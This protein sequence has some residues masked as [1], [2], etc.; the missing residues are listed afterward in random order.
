MDDIDRAALARTWRQALAAGGIE[1]IEAGT[2]G[3]R[4]SGLVDRLAA[5]LDAEPF[6]ATVGV[7]VGAAL[8]AADF[9]DP[10][11]P[12]LS[13]P[14]LHALAK[15][16]AH[17]DAGIR[18]GGLLAGL[19]QGHQRKVDEVSE[20]DARFRVLFDSTGVAIA[21][22]DTDGT[23]VDANPAL[24]DMI[25]IPVEN[26]RGISVY[27]FAHPDDRDTIRTLLYEKLVPA[28]EGTVTLDQRL[29]RA[30]GSIGW[31]TFAITYVRGSHGRSDCLLAIGADV[32]ERHLLQEE[33]HR[34]AR[35]DPL[36]GLPN[37]RFLLE[38]IEELIA[39]ADTDT[40]TGLCFADLDHFKHVN[41][42][43]GHRVGDRVLSEAADRLYR[44]VHES[45]CFV[46]RLGGDEFVALI[47]PPTDGDTVSLFAD[48]MLAA[49][50][51]PVIVDGLEIEISASIGA[52]V[53][54]LAHADA[55]SLLDAAD[56]GLRSAKRNSKGRWV[57]HT[58]ASFD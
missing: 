2:D 45:G 3:L 44:A 35:H 48:R 40:R 56:T 46:C 39:D 6:D 53:T 14:V 9:T 22:G 51:E 36:T 23:L 16:S 4:L 33:L 26:L 1:P 52:V 41:D 42:H 5:A 11:V 30:D 25:G 17:P 19:G 49:F 54:S 13:A 31:M 10:M 50:D 20:Q 15:A 21:I 38:R 55:E 29:V 47:E 43:Y 27:D 24:A 32:T 12:I 34:Q 57:M 18:L 58:Q 8:W 28:G 37:R 7:G